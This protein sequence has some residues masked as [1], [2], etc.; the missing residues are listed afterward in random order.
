[1][2]ISSKHDAATAIL[3]ALTDKPQTL[4]AISRVTCLSISYLEQL[5]S[6]LRKAKL[7]VPHRGPGGGYTLS[8]PLSEITVADIFSAMDTGSQ[9]KS[10]GLFAEIRRRVALVVLSDF[11]AGDKCNAE[12]QPCTK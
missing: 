3:L 9:R 8:R 2:K 4:T 1:M 10:S 5:A 12:A 11:S 7:I 6:D